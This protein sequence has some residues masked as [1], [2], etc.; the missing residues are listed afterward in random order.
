MLTPGPDAARVTAVVPYLA[1]ARKDAKT[2]TRDPVTTRYVAQL[3]E[4]VG[5]DR[6][7]RATATER[8]VL[9]QLVDLV[10]A[11]VV[12]AGND[13]PAVREDR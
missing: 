2:Q 6:V 4:A 7:E 1:Y 3:F 13:G 9:E 10:G 8:A 5:T 11:D 12:G